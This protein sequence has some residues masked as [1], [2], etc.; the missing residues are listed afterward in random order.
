MGA[1]TMNK[2]TATIA[3]FALL[4]A[5]CGKK[6]PPPVVDEAH[7]ANDAA[8]LDKLFTDLLA[9]AKKKDDARAKVYAES[10]KLPEPA[11][12]FTTTFGA[13][14]GAS[15]AAEYDAEGYAGFGDSAAEGL[16]GLLA[17]GRTDVTTSCHASADDDA[18]TGYQVS[19]LR[20]MKQPAPLC[21]VRISDPGSDKGYTLWS[22]T[23]V[24]GKFRFV[25]K[26]KKADTHEVDPS[27][28]TE[29]DM[30]AELPVR[31]AREILGQ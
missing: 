24:D 20:A 30:L 5:A 15:L 7:Y 12:W 14:L 10:L 6:A 3:P 2:L 27:I 25:G 17:Q 22:F 23:W 13:E 11:A 21:T 8:G 19:A 16:R 26:M 1:A 31:D 9:A 4:L 29:M 18:A 28:A